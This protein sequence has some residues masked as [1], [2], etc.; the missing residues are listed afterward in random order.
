MKNWIIIIMFFLSLTLYGQDQLFYLGDTDVP[1][2]TKEKENTIELI[3]NKKVFNNILK[4]RVKSEVIEIPFITGK[5]KLKLDRFNFYNSDIKFFSKTN[6]GDKELDITPTLLSYKMILDGKIVGII[7]F[8]N[9]KI[10]ASFKLENKQFEITEF[11]GNY[12]LF[13]A[14]NSINSSN[15]SC[16]V[17]S[18]YESIAPPISQLPQSTPVCVELAVVIDFYTRQTFNSDLE[19]INW[20]LAI[21]AGVSQI[22]ES[23][24][25]AAIQVTY[26]YIWNIMDPYASSPGQAGAM[27][28]GLRNYWQ[29]NNAA[30]NRDLVHLLTKRSNT[31][32]GGIAYLDVLCSN[33]S[34][35]GFSSDLN[36]DTTYTFPN[37]S[38]TWNLFVC[39]HEIGHNFGANHTFWCGWVSDPSIP[40]AGGV[41]DNCVDVEGSCSNNPSPQLGTIMSYCHTTSGG[42]ILDFHEVV[43]SQALNP[44]ISNA[45][46]LT[47]CDYYGCTDPLAFNY[48]ATATVDDG[49]CIPIIFG[50]IDFIATNYNSSANTDDGS[51]TYCSDISFNIS[52]IS[53]NDY[54]DGAIN[55]IINNG[56]SPFSFNWTGPN[57][58]SA[59]SQNLNNLQ[60]D[61]NYSVI[62]TDALQCSDTSIVTL[63]NPDTISIQN[64]S[65]TQVTCNGL[66]NGSFNLTPIG[67]TP[68]YSIN[69]GVNN[70]SQLPAGTY[71]VAISDINNC[72]AYNSN[73]IITEPTVLTESIIIENISC[74]NLSDGSINLSI[75]GGTFPYSSIWTGLGGF[76]STNEDIFQLLEDTYSVVITDV[77]NCSL[78]VEATITNP[79]PLQYTISSQDVSC[80][81]GDDGSISLNISGGI[82]PYNYLWNNSSISQNLTSISAGSYSVNVTDDKG[83]ALPTIYTNII[84][85]NPSTI[86][87][88]HTNISCFGYSNGSINISY[89]PVNNNIFYN[90]EWQG[91]NSFTATTADVNLISAGLYTLNITENNNCVITRYF[92]ITEPDQLSTIEVIEP[93]SCKGG[94]DGNSSLIISGGVP[95]YTINWNNANPLA[96]SSGIYFYSISDTN[97]CILND[98]ILITEPPTSIQ[99]IDSVV[100]V[101]CFNGSDGQ[102]FLD[103]SGGGPPYSINWLNSNPL[104]LN[105]GTHYYELKDSNNCL[106]LDSVI[107]NQPSK[108]LVNE[109]IANA[110][111][112]GEA[113]GSAILNV[114]GGLAPYTYTWF[115]VNNLSLL[116][117]SYIYNVA[118]YNNCIY[119]GLAIIEQ[120]NDIIA[121]S[122]VTQ[123]SC[124]STNDGSV[125]LNISGGI[126]PYNINWGGVN[127]ANLISGNYDFTVIDSN[128]C[129]DSNQVIVYPLSN[130]LVQPTIDNIS[131]F[132]KCNGEISLL[133]TNGILPYQIEILD[134]SNNVQTEDSLCKGWYTYK[135]LDALSCLFVDS[136]EILSPN[137]LEG[138]IVYQGNLLEAIVLGGTPPYYYEWYDINGY[139]IGS[140]STIP[141]LFP[142]EYSCLVY[143]S[144]SCLIDT[145]SI[146]TEVLSMNTI[147]EDKFLVYPNPSSGLIYINYEGT[148]NE[149]FR[150]DI[151][152]Y[153]GQSVYSKDFFNNKNIIQM[154]L[155]VLSSG[156]YHLCFSTENTFISKKIVIQ[157]KE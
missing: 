119:S 34:G 132:G 61:G 127:P 147:E 117:G 39:S 32:T 44:G 107:I 114:S 71:S 9:N 111:C 138:N 102:A 141:M 129:I 157:H 137:K 101:S 75:S 116:A 49:S 155:D 83:C 92:D 64:I 24:T 90:Y 122:I 96:L 8:V 100:P 154:N 136:F 47:I 151:K 105:A 10:V 120:P 37:P 86:I 54:N 68:P 142:G 135:V 72:P 58:F 81:S 57:G 115:G 125:D 109:I 29:T 144:E 41:I 38:Y 56:N 124:F 52:N 130:I 128:L 93:V 17:E 146:N 21:F 2:A 91:P 3:L 80:N 27:L 69:Y 1:S 6:K 126:P 88:A 5:L 123:S 43:V 16:A 131:C 73:V 145:L 149:H 14:T 19:S 79:L 23:E 13:E 60:D 87:D 140:S 25:N 53:C 94:N 85:P 35:Y 78:V 48:D 15:F 26:T 31:G 98:S 148:L 99:I 42:S 112:Y 104:N 82:A 95:F 113:S 77:Y 70:P 143:D 63:Y 66:S 153:L 74:N 89:T 59:N 110:K 62:V 121:S 30:I 4:N 50:C 106:L 7:N 55:L 134:S 65:I 18:N 76:Y 156:V 11:N 40:F 103:P 67:G 152:N 28:A 20:A 84:E 133:V 108:I 150:L 36:N 139:I 97:Q 46:C 45:S 33:N 118:D 12:V 22:Y 51:C